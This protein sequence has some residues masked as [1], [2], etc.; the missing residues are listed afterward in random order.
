MKAVRNKSSLQLPSLLIFIMHLSVKYMESKK[1][2]IKGRKRLCPGLFQPE[3]PIVNILAEFPVCTF[4][5]I[6]V[7]F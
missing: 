1:T 2:K 4:L 6:S 5:H 7:I 3:I